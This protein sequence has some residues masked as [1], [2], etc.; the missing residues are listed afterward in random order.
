MNTASKARFQIGLEIYLRKSIS[1][2]NATCKRKGLSD[3]FVKT[4]QFKYQSGSYG[5]EET[6]I[7]SADLIASLYCYN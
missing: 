6:E 2:I 4:R 3:F 1:L 7:F 5:Y